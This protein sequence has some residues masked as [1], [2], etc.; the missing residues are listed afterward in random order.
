MGA[1]VL[2]SV[3]KP[4]LDSTIPSTWG[5]LSVPPKLLPE[6]CYNEVLEWWRLQL[7]VDG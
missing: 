4:L 5:S 1:I 3:P 2:H 7:R 6:P